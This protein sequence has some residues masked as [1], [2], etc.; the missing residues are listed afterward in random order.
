MVKEDKKEA[1]VIYELEARPVC[2]T[3]DTILCDPGEN[4]KSPY[5]SDTSSIKRIK[6]YVH[7]YMVVHYVNGY[8]LYTGLSGKYIK[9]F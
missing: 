7:W 3:L 5:A 6:V 4:Y 1:G 2:W 8:N 9:C